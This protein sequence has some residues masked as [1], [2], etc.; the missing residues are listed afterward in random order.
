MGSDFDAA[1]RAARRAYEL[2]RLRSSA[3]R[4]AMVAAV[5][6]AA[7]VVAVGPDALAW[8]PV[9]LLVWIFIEWRGTWLLRGARGGLLAGL[10][11]LALPLSILRPCC[12]L[13]ADMSSGT[14]C[15]MPGAC[16]VVGAMLGLSLALVVPRV[17]SERRATT[18]IGMVLGVGSVAALRCGALL[19]GEAAGLI[20]G[21]V[22][23]VVAANLARA[24][25]DRGEL[26]AHS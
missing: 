6:A 20:G 25:M 8:V 17:P 12:R 10:T 15:T 22:A 23:G 4:A 24:W 11:T 16:V 9:T 19:F 21:L 13:D 18:A 3:L 14:C 26:G 1:R 2:G 5:S 7:A